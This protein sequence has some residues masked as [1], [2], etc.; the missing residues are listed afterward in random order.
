MAQILLANKNSL[1]TR[2]PY[3][4]REDRMACIMQESLPKFPLFQPHPLPRP[5]EAMLAISH[6]QRR[7]QSFCI[8]VRRLVSGQ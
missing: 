1:T 8:R 7:L 3:E 4:D 6:S 2:Q 5:L